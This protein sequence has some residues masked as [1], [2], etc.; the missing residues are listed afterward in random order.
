MGRSRLQL[1]RSAG[2]QE[3]DREEK[4]KAG[5]KKEKKKNRCF[6]IKFEKNRN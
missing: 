5:R 1:L 2:G 4:E 6:F 3:R